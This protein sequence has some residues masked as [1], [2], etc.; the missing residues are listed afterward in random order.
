MTPESIRVLLE[1]VRAG[2]ISVEEALER[3][4]ALP[5]EDLG[6]AKPDHHRALRSGLPEAIL[7][8]GKTVDQIVAVAERVVAAGGPLI[9]TRASREVFEALQAVVPRAQYE[10]AARVITARGPDV[11]EPTGSIAIVTAGTA[12]L[13]VAEEARVTAEFLGS[14]TETF[15]DVG[16]A[17]L[18]RLLS[19]AD[20]VSRSRVVVV[21]AGMDAVLPSVIGGLVNRPLIGIPT[22]VGY[23]AAFGGIAPLLTML[24]SCAPG[25][26]VVN[27]DNGFGAACLAH[28][29]N[30]L[31]ACL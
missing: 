29:I 8:E 15:Y 7:C 12:D 10:P 31:D 2:G 5:F 19:V 28:R 24:N 22:S 30:Q 13:P 17:G 6:F 20:R 23:G 21:A 14:R 9:A 4:R 16:V 18:P 25:V 3:L 26:A 27:I 1:K 11:P